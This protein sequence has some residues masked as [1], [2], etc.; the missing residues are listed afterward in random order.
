MFLKSVIRSILKSNVKNYNIISIYSFSTTQQN[1]KNES[2]ANSS[3]LVPLNNFYYSLK[4]KAGFQGRYRYRQPQMAIAGFRLYLCIQKQIDYKK[5]FKVC[6]SR[7]VYFSFCLI[8]YLHVWM[9]CVRL[10]D[11]G[12]SGKYVRN[13]LIESMYADIA[14]RMKKLGRID[15]KIRA[16]NAEELNGIFNACFF[17]YDEGILSDDNVLA[18]CIWRHL[19]EMRDIEDFSVF[20]TLCD[21][22]R[23][24]I[25]HLDSIKEVDL[26]KNGI[27]TI[28]PLGMDSIDQVKESKK[29]DDYIN[30]NV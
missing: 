12:I 16:K 18:A 30:N 3:A 2:T 20:R 19:L 21:Y 9:V 26:L 28:I 8:T 15:I 6:N 7:D 1:R 23:K 10:A 27:I 22:I 14:E 13:R 29:L 17:G 4:E 25:S 11:E 24:N 5:W